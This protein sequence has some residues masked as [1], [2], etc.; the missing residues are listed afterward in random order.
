MNQNY[1]FIDGSALTAQIRQLQRAIPRFRGQRLCPKSLIN[2]FNM[3]LS[4]L[5]GNSYKRVTFY[6]PKGDEAAIEDFI[7]VPSHTTPGEIRDLHFK[8]CGHKMKKSAEFDKFVEE[9]VPLKF[10]SRFQKS[11]KGIDIEMCCDALRLASRNRL[12]RIFLLSNDGDFLPLCR[13]L[14]EFGANISILHLSS[15]TLPNLELLKE[16]D[17]YDV[18]P[19]EHLDSVFLAAPEP[20]DAADVADSKVIGTTTPGEAIEL[21]NWGKDSEEPRSEKPDAAPADLGELRSEIQP[22]DDS[23]APVS[24][25]RGSAGKKGNRRS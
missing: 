8:F 6:F 14:K 22:D 17:T 19:E 10:Q 23:P 4:D 21:I 13:T 18:V 5:H 11:E 2:Y 9:K 24:K 16:S 3:T 7:A 12:E 1:F 20:I 25:S 15:V